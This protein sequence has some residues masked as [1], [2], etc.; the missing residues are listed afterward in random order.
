MTEF[1][2]LIADQPAGQEKPNV[3]A[4]QQALL[5]RK[6]LPLATLV[7]GDYYAG[8]LGD[9][10]TIGRWHGTRRRFVAWEHEM[11]QAKLK[12]APHVADA[13]TG[14]RFAPLSQKQADDSYHVSDFALETTR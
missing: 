7:H 5:D 1:A 3:T 9:M 12:A 8:F 10:N 4:A 2:V 13:G 6:V 11:G 14:P